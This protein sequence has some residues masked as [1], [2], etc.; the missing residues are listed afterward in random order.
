MKNGMRNRIV[1]GL[2]AAAV[3][4]LAVPALFHAAVPFWIAGLPLVAG[5]WA[6]TPLARAAAMAGWMAVP[7]ATSAF[8]LAGIGQ[9]GAL[10]WTGAAIVV[11]ACAVL[12]A[13]LGIATV[14]IALTLVPV[15]PASPVVVLADTLPG[16]GLIGLGIAALCLFAVE[17][18]PR[19][20]TPL[21]L[22]LVGLLGAWKIQSPPPG[23]S[24]WTAIPEPPGAS[25]RGRWL[26]ILELVPEGATAILGEAVFRD[27]DLAAL[28][29][30]CRAAEA[31][32]LTL[33]IG[34]T[35]TW[36]RADR[37]AVWRLDRETCAPGRA[38]AI[39]E[40]AWL[41]IPGVTGGWRPMPRA[42]GD[43]TGPDFLICLEGF[44]PWSWARLAAARASR[45][46]VVVSNDGAFGS[47]P[48]HVMRRK[49]AGA[50]AALDDRAVA[51]AETGRTVLVRAAQRVFD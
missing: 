14:T 32:D 49:A 34:V 15:F 40:R 27:G 48:V 45:D 28:G 2:I 6:G 22:A 39:A 30:W 33:F 18:L 9:P 7:A 42:G 11:V 8:G 26:A 47:L 41:G 19:G 5:I 17:H 25:E 29:F 10:V 3:P 50:M 20:R 24:A 23:P 51:H 37:G 21:L 35:E 38:P 36:R 31:R 43:A 44:L 4:A 1:A 12:A 16:L 46:V 13:R